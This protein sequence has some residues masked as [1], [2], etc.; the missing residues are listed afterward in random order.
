MA[1]DPAA[2]PEGVA[3]EDLVLAYYDADTGE[4]VELTDIVVDTVNNTV[5]GT[6][7]HFTQFAILAEVEVTPTPAPTVT[8][9]ETPTPTVAPT[10]TI[11]PTP[12]VAPTEVP[13]PTETP[14]PTEEPT[15]APTT[16]PDEEDDDDDL[17]PWVI[18]GPIIGI[19]IIGLLAYIAIRRKGI[20]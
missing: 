10:P 9:T 15:P 8:P 4:W 7:S 11:E 16:E 2:L 6:T 12:T 18:I 3:A 20:A 5:S 13:T 19:A 17:N 1:Y 14:E